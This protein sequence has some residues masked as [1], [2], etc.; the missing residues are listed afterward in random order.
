MEDKSNI[1]HCETPQAFN[2][3]IGIR[4]YHPLISVIDF[5]Q[6]AEYRHPQGW[7]QDYYVIALCR[8]NLSCDVKYGRNKYDYSDGTLVFTSPGQTVEFQE[9]GE[10]FC[11][12]EDNWAIMVHPDFIRG[13][14]L[15]RDIGNYIFFS[16]EIHE[17]LHLS[18]D[19]IEQVLDIF[20]HIRQELEKQI[21]EY[22]PEIVCSYIGTLL[23]Y[24]RRFYDRQFKMRHSENMDIVSH[25]EKLLRDYFLT[26][27]L[28]QN[29]LP[30]V[31]YFADR[32]SLSPDY[33]TAILQRETGMNTR[34]HIQNRIIETAKDKLA[35]DSHSISQIAYELGF[36]YPQ[37]FTRLFKQQT[38]MTPAEYRQRKS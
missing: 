37:Y 35:L 14:S 7:K 38:G 34:K 1:I 28:A 27:T 29:G 16:Y 15:G 22:T 8:G 2:R 9:Y 19:E 18:E 33:L 12:A 3:I 31:K 5:S 23:S 30:T 20:K 10:P 4:T 26:N 21:D 36:E 25:F 13:T 32:M 6:I 11:P 17:A 24:C